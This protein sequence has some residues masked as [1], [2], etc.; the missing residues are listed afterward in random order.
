MSI[1]VSSP[2]AMHGCLVTASNIVGLYQTVAATVSSQEVSAN[3]N[4]GNCINFEIFDFKSDVSIDV[5]LP[6]QTPTIMVGNIVTLSGFKTTDLD[7]AYIC[8]GM[9][10]TSSNVD[11]VKQNISVRRFLQNSIPAVSV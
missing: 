6:S 8:V 9:G 4:M 1:P 2:T 3:D 7:G 11:F 5:T 10:E